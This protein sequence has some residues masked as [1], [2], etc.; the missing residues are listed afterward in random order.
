MT[1]RLAT[2]LSF[3][4]MLGFVALLIFGGLRLTRS[5]CRALMGRAR[6]GSD[7]LVVFAARPIHAFPSCQVVLP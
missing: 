2:A 1:Q 3:G 6:S 4:L 5:Q 7:S